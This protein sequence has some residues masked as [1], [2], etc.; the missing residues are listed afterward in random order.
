MPRLKTETATATA[1]LLD[2]VGVCG[3]DCTADVDGDGVCDDE[4]DCVGSLDACGICNGPGEIYECGCTDIASGACDCDGNEL[5]ALGVCGGG[6]AADANGNGICDDAEVLGCT[7][8][9]ACNY[10]SSANVEDGSCE[11]CSCFE[12]PS[13]VYTLAVESTPSAFQ[14][15]TVYRFYIQTLNAEDQL[16]AMFSYAPFEFRVDAPSGVFNSALNSTWNASGLSPAF[17]ALYPEMADDTYAT[18]GLE[19]PASASGL[20]G[21]SDPT[22]VE[23]SDQ[24]ISPFFLNDGATSLL[25][26]F[27]IW[28]VLVCDRRCIERDCGRGQACVVH[29]SEHGGSHFRNGECPDF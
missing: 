6:C 5:D 26:Q 13:T 4:D 15:L 21:A 17:V 29:A 25:V 3:G 1:T 2:E 19:G 10:D 16:S 22:L 18:L 7:D 27:R 20:E 28:R 14:D 9:S 8:G 23:D 11:F 24:P 12:D